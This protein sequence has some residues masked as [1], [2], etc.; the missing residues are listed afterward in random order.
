VTPLDVLAE[1]DRLGIALAA[2]DLDRIHVRPRAWLTPELAAAITANRDRVLALLKLREIHRAM[3][4]SEADVRMIE[5]ALLS[6][7]VTE[8]RIAALPPVE[9]Q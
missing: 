1:A 5:S 3:G 8:I 7:T 4:F 9:A 6:G 2:D